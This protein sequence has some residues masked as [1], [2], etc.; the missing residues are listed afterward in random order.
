MQEIK[1]WIKIRTF[2]E[3][4]KLSKKLFEMPYTH[5]VSIKIPNIFYASFFSFTLEMHLSEVSVNR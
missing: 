2:P 1:K 3:Y 5:N 4:F